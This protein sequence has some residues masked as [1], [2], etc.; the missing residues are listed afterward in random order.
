MARLQYKKYFFHD[1]IELQQT[2]KQ[3]L[4]I[5]FGNLDKLR[6]EENAFSSSLFLH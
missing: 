3:I 1:H 5:T 6:K 4:K 2:N